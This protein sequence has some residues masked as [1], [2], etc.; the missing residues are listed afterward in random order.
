MIRP[1]DN[2]FSRTHQRL[3]PFLAVALTVSLLALLTLPFDC[4]I[5]GLFHLGDGIPGDLRKAIE[6]SEFFAH[7]FG[8]AVILIGLAVLAPHLRSTL[9]RLLAF[10]FLPSVLVHILKFSIARRRPIS[11]NGQLPESSAETFMGWF[12][13]LSEPALEGSGYLINSF[14]SG[15]TATA[16]GLA[17]GLSWLNPRG[18]V[19]FFSLASLAAMQRIVSG[20]HWASDTIFSLAIATAAAGLLSSDNRLTHWFSRIEFRSNA[21]TSEDQ[22]AEKQNSIAA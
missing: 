7:G 2:D 3:L 17:F 21:P 15:H 11:F 6:L 5:A 4:S 16:F 20:A 22:Y 13:K 12:P 18:R 9:P 14:P 8:V 19:Y 1:L 10:A